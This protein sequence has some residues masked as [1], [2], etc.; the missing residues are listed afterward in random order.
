MA[1]AN[2]MTVMTGEDVGEFIAEVEDEQKRADSKELVRLMSRVTGMKPKMWGSIVGFGQYHYKYDSGHEG[3]TCLT[4]FA[5]RKS[6]LSIYIHGGVYPGVVARRDAL[7]ARLGKHSMGKGCLYVKRLKDVDMKVLE[8]LVT[9]SVDALRSE[10][11]EQSRSQRNG[12]K[13]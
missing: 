13:S 9:L 8:E 10:F 5:P 11:P 12:R 3:D 7:L 4:G 1:R 2:T 6:A